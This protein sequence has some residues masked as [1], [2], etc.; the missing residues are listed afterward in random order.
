MN[1]EEVSIWRR[2]GAL[3][4]PR[5]LH[6]QNCTA[7]SDHVSRFVGADDPVRPA[8]CTREP[9]RTNA[10]PYHVCRGRCPHRPAR[11]TSVFTKRC[12]KFV[13]APRA[14]RGVRPYR[15]LCGFADNACKFSIAPCRV[16]VGID[17]Y[18]HITL[19]PFIVRVC[20]C[21]LRG[22]GKPRP[23]VTTKRGGS[24]KIRTLLLIRL[25]ARATFPNM[26]KAWGCANQPPVLK[27]NEKIPRDAAGDSPFSIKPCR[28]SRGRRAACGGRA[29]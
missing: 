14:D 20:G 17:P 12:G 25:A 18:G 2:G 22:R 10:K 19:S 28:R 16:D 15:T 3:P 5:R 6:H 7:S 8:V 1:S 29:P 4:R 23:Y 27:T 24:S 13:I 26:G 21:V 11:G 9:G